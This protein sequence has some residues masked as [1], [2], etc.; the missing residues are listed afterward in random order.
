MADIKLIQGTRTELTPADLIPDQGDILSTDLHQLAADDTTAHAD[1]VRVE[2]EFTAGSADEAV[3]I[4][5]AQSNAAG[6]WL[7]GNATISSATVAVDVLPNL[8]PPAPVIVQAA[9][10]K[11]SGVFRCTAAAFVIVVESASTLALAGLKV[12]V[13]PLHYNST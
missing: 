6:T 7:D 8:G 10:T 11:G 4:Y 3:N 12:F 5:L 13:T 9:G 1:E 2:V